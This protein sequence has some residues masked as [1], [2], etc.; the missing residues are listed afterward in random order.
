MS[1]PTQT[2]SRQVFSDEGPSQDLSRK[3]R[4]HTFILVH[5]IKF[6]I[7][8]LQGNICPL[9]Y[10][11]TPPPNHQRANYN[12]SSLYLL[13]W[14]GC[15]KT[16]GKIALYTVLST[17]DGNEKYCIHTCYEIFLLCN[18]FFFWQRTDDDA[19]I[20]D[21]VIWYWLYCYS[22]CNLLSYS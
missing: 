15:K 7:L 10:F 16:W 11:L 8:Y 20:H 2:G 4:I 22:L 3:N 18:F 1:L 9:F 19:S 17:K 14:K 6:N 13:L 21:Q 5:A 12:F